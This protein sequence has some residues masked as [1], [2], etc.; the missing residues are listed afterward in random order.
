MTAE[1][2]VFQKPRLGPEAIAIGSPLGD[3]LMELMLIDHVELYRPD[4]RCVIRGKLFI[5][6]YI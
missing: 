4:I 2:G 3:Q 1:V 6:Y 5:F